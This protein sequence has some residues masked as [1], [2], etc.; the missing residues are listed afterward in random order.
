VKEDEMGMSCNTHERRGMHAGFWWKSQKERDHYEDLDVG[1]SIKWILI[2]I[3]WGGVD[4]IDLAQDRDRW[5]TLMN[6]VMNLRVP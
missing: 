4:W 1:G 2:E 6:T 5:R 3:G